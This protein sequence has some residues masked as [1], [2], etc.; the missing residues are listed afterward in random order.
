MNDDIFLI[1][2]DE[3]FK[4]FADPYRMEII[5]IYIDR[6]TPLTVKMVADIL[7]E[8]PAKV[9][10]HVQKLLKIGVLVLDHIEIINGINA[11]Y[12]KLTK[13]SFKFDIKDNQS[14]KMKTFKI[15]S[16]INNMIKPL[17]VFREEII[18]Y[19]EAVKKIQNIEDEKDDA[20]ITLRN[21][22]L[23]HEEFEE[24]R[25]MVF[26]FVRDKKKERENTKRYAFL[27]S[28]FNKEKV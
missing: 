12:Y 8:V 4:V 20:Y 22:Y 11:K 10:Y 13:T 28:I 1:K 5:D 24:F 6:D 23:T 18:N 25:K 27:S 19:G 2:T 14:S 3:E 17:D 16:T 15:D 7:G 9:H 21:I 26:K